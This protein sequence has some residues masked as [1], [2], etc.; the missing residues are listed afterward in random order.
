MRCLLCNGDAIHTADFMI[1]RTLGYA[2][3]VFAAVVLPLSSQEMD[4][5][6]SSASG[7]VQA[8]DPYDRYQLAVLSEV[9][10]A[11][12]DPR[13]YAQTRLESEYRNRTDNGAYALLVRA[14]PVSPLTLNPLLSKAA[15]GYA[16][17]LAE[18]NRF[19]HNEQ[20]TPFQRMNKEGYRYS[21]A[22]ENIACGSFPQQNALLEPE[23]AAVVFVKQWI[24]DKGV[25]GVG[26][27]K[28]ILSPMFREIGVGFGRNE[29]STYV[30]YTV[31]DFGTAQ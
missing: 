22:G 30:N 13:I 25:A 10:L 6:A 9:N 24:I 8:A 15:S 17:F 4:R 23:K 14:A 5:E 2:A 3:F 19:G 18:K 21:T 26:H 16:A 1:L 28:N 27:R 11:R 7:P 29:R 12:T 31:Q 20:G